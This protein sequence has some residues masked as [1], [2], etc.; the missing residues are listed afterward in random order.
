MIDIRYKIKIL[1]IVDQYKVDLKGIYPFAKSGLQYD[2][3]RNLFLE[4]HGTIIDIKHNDNSGVISI[5]ENRIDKIELDLKEN[6]SAYGLISSLES[7]GL[8][9]CDLYDLRNTSFENLIE[10]YK[11]SST[12]SN[13]ADEIIAF[14]N[15]EICFLYHS[16]KLIN[17]MI[18][19]NLFKEIDIEQMFVENKL[20][21]EFER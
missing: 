3:E 21:N 10:L 1:G 13:Y 17:I 5:K 16:D 14:Y 2:F 15:D 8:K 11:A 12:N 7:K 19:D 6:Y 4:H 9:E 18:N 20:E